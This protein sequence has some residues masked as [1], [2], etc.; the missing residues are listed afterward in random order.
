[1]GFIRYAELGMFA[2]NSKKKK[3]KEHHLTS[4]SNHPPT[5]NYIEGTAATP[6]VRIKPPPRVTAQDLLVGFWHAWKLR[7]PSIARTTLKVSRMDQWSGGLGPG[8]MDRG[9]RMGQRLTSDVCAGLR[10]ISVLLARVDIPMC[11]NPI[12]TMRSRRPAGLVTPTS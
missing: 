5:N 12:P 11:M 9:G 10:L 7:H 3:K 6:S 1:M 2:G 4:S 8:V